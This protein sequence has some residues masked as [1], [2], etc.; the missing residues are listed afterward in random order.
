MTK[1]KQ[2]AKPK[3]FES[4]TLEVETSAGKFANS[5]RLKRLKMW[6]VSETLIGQ[7]RIFVFLDFFVLNF[8]EDQTNSARKT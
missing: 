5:L 6:T 7:E 3:I 4:Y 1:T 8:A 2:M